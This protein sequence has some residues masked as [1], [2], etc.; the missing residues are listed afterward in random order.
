MRPARASLGIAV[1]GPYLYWS[2]VDGLNRSSI[3]RAR[4]DG[5]DARVLLRMPSSGHGSDI[6]R[7]FVPLPLQDS[8]EA[9]EGLA[10]DGQYL[11]FSRCQEN[12]IGRVAVN[13]NESNPNFIVLAGG[14]CPQGIVVAG[15]RI[16]WT[17]L[18]LEGP[19][20]IG[21]S[22][23]DGSD[24]N[25]SWLVMPSS[26]AGGPWSLAASGEHL[27]FIWG[28]TPEFAP[29][30]IG[31]ASLNGSPHATLRMA[32]VSGGGTAIAIAP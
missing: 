22:N 10:T 24:Q 30:F 7:D 9:A 19:G 12:A 11:Y 5:A 8:G 23:L 18:G 4:L 2:E 3:W 32:R 17:S 6:Q 25:D 29:T 14:R 21:E 28:G 31:S 20:V 26:P 13:G 15:T 1:D 27:F 16:F